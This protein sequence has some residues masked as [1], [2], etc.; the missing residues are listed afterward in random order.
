M[1]MEFNFVRSVDS[2]ET[3]LGSSLQYPVKRRRQYWISENFYH[4]N[5]TE[6]IQ[7]H[8]ESRASKNDAILKSRVFFSKSLLSA[9]AFWLFSSV[10]KYI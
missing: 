9:L 2:V 1:N 8:L 3:F 6:D 10:D 4:E 5:A 7:T